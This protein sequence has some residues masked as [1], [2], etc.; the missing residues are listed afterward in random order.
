MLRINAILRRSR[1]TVAPVSETVTFGPFIYN[2]LRRELKAD[3]RL[4]RLT[5]RELDM[6]RFLGAHPL[7]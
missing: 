4:V 2:Y 5:D 7:R 3:G 1:E 6:L